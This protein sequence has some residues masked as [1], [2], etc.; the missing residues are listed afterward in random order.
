MWGV[1][2]IMVMGSVVF[3]VFVFFVFMLVLVLDVRDFFYIIV[4]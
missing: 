2:E 1:L 4:F 3:K